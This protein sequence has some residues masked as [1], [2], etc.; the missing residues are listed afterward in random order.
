MN[1]TELINSIASKSGLS[2]KNSE[3]ALNAF[4]A[5]VEEALKKGDKVVLV[6]FG[7]FEV[8]NRAARKGRN[9]QTKEEITI[10]ASKAPVFK[11]GK[12]LKDIV[13]K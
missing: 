8:K 6:G 11:A 13:N 9:P 4:I 3:A 5:S 7:T 2:K 12:G 10:P 1:K